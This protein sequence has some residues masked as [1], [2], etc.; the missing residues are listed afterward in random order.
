MGKE[1]NIRWKG[2]NADSQNVRDV[3][4]PGSNL[5]PNEKVGMIRA[6]SPSYARSG[7]SFTRAD[8]LM[9]KVHPLIQKTRRPEVLKNAGRFAGLFALKK[10]RRPVLVSSTD[11]VGTKLKY[12]AAAGRHEEVGIDCVA[13]NVNDI[14]T[15]GA[16][17][18]FFLDYVA[19]GRIKERALLLLL[20][21][22]SRG[23][24]EAGCA[25]ISGETAEM[26]GF[27]P[28]GEYDIAGFAVG[29]VEERELIDGKSVAKG[30]LILGLA[31]SGLHSN[32]FSLVRKIFPEKKASRAFL[33]KLLR[34]TR[35]YVKPVLSLRK[36]FCLKAISHITGG[37]LYNRVFQN[38]PAARHAVLYEKSWPI[39]SIFLEIEKRGKLSRKEMF[40]TFNMGIGLA[41]VCRRKDSGGIQR[42]LTSFG[43]S[44]WVIGEVV[45]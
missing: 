45:R 32:G 40:R 26:P 21:G 9:Q 10:Y 23:C 30:D 34:P 16:E 4:R 12:A 29:V 20:R 38:I 36:R 18:L 41:L 27:F 39:P 24:R 31:S 5:S 11:G 6:D 8:R 42:V 2:P 22:V 37:G 1:T 3:F 33:K 15:F 28:D 43:I 7:V 14:V 35:I 13:M 19:T 17:P 44:S 25:L